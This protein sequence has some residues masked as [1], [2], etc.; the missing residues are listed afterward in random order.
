MTNLISFCDQATHLVNEGKAV[1]VIYLDF[2][3]AFDIVSH[4]IL[5]ERLA[6]HGLDMC[7]LHWVKSWL[8]GQAQR[9]WW[10]YT[11]LNPVDNHKWFSIG[12][13]FGTYP[14]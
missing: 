7:T 2:S 1:N 6:V 12:V 9:E 5:L 3:K 14:V 11:E 8:E 10:W 13:G 4:M